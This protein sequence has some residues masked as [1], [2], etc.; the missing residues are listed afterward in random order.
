MR[1]LPFLFA[2][3]FMSISCGKKSETNSS[4]A[5]E[6]TCQLGGM[7]VACETIEG[8]DG[9]GVDLL[10]TI[11]DVPINLSNSEITFQESKLSADEGRRISCKTQVRNGEVYQYSLRGDQLFIQ[12]E[13]GS[14]TMT[15][16]NDEKNGILGTWFWQGYV[17]QGTLLL[18]TMTFVSQSRVILKTHCEL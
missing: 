14:Y 16:N 11:I 17:D 10:D 1:Y 3:M 6:S 7:A 9:L 12:T 2:M 5:P 4:L 15:R 18:R 13:S 8:S